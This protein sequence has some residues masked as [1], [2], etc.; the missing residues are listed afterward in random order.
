MYKF[1]SYVQFHVI[2]PSAQMPSMDV[3]RF[4]PLKEWEYKQREY[5]KNTILKITV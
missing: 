2:S 1:T 5:I 4:I 3:K